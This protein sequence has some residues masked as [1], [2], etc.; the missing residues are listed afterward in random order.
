MSRSAAATL[1]GWTKTKAPNS[2]AAS[3]T[4]SR[5]GVVEVPP[6]DMGR[7]VKSEKSAGTHRPPQFPRCHLRRLHRKRSQPAETIRVFPNKR[8]DLIVLDLGALRAEGGLLIVEE[9]LGG[10]RQELDVHPGLVHI[11]EAP[12]QIPGL[13]GKGLLGNPGYLQD[14]GALVEGLNPEGK[15]RCRFLQQPYRLLGKDVRMNVY[16]LVLTHR[17]CTSP[18]TKIRA[19]PKNQGGRDFRPGGMVDCRK[20]FVKANPDHLLLIDT[21]RSIAYI[22]KNFA[23]KP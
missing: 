5:V 21:S 11:P 1:N 13:A 2:R 17:F 7:Q 12:L 4:G 19:L 6:P 14:A 3:Q 9:R 16:C 8:G 22:K 10:V 23:R 20:V 15:R 18:M